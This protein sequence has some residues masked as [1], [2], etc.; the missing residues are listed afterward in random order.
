M[1]DSTP[2]VTSEAS[3]ATSPDRGADA[4]DVSLAVA[5]DRRAF[6]RLYRRHVGRVLGLAT[7]D[8]FVRA[9]E[10]LATFRGEAAFG[11]WLYRLAVN[12]IL[13]RRA[14]LGARRTRFI[15]DD[16]VLETVPARP[17]ATDAGLDFESAMGKL[18]PGARAVFVLHDVEGYRHNEIAELLDV[19]T[20]TTKAQLHRAR[21]ML[22]RHLEA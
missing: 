19:T 10:K 3:Q 9:W 13:S 21:M 14:W 18:P 8:V 5:G 2:G 11:T 12:L 7:Q 4:E 20:G 1:H 6:E 17:A 16:M 22:R 15:A